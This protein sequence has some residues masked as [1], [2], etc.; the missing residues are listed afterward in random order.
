MEIFWIRLSR[1]HKRP[2]TCKFAI[3]NRRDSSALIIKTR[4]R[5]IATT[6]AA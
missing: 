2:I 1:C 4:W 3:S 6:D 5:C